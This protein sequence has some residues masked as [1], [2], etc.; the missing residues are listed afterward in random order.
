M[1]S[2]GQFEKKRRF[3]LGKVKEQIN[4]RS[5]RY[6]CH[7]ALTSELEGIFARGDRR[8]SGVIVDAYKRGCMFDA[9][10]DYFKADVWEQALEDNGVSKYF[11]N[12]RERGKDEIFPWDF[13]D[14]GVSKQ[15]LWREYE[16]AGQEKV[17]PNC[18]EGCGGCGARKFGTGVCVEQEGVERIEDKNEIY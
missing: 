1:D 3:L 15:F 2:A 17:T 4:Q 18:R 5:I 16:R 14:I 11:Y 9:W 7:D 12:Y 6:N 13:I 8:L 10:T